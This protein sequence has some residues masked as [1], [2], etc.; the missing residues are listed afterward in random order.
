VNATAEFARFVVRSRWEDV[1]A[2]VRHKGK[3][4]RARA[5]FGAPACRIDR[6][7]DTVWRIAEAPDAAE[8]A[9]LACK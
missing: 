9:R 2:T 1:P 6:V 7:F 8:L 4:T 3:R 5:Q